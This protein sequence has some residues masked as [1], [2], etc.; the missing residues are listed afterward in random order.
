VVIVL[1]DL[2]TGDGEVIAVDLDNLVVRCYV[3][4][5]GK[6]RMECSST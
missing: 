6:Y 5:V 1:G 3:G 2:M 4:W